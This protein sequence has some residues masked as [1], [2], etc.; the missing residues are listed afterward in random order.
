MR[1]WPVIVSKPELKNHILYASLIGR[2]WVLEIFMVLL[3]I[4]SRQWNIVVTIYGHNGTGEHRI[5]V[6]QVYAVQFALEIKF[7]Q[8]D[9]F[10]L[11]KVQ[12]FQLSVIF[13]R[14]YFLQQGKNHIFAHFVLDSINGLVF[15]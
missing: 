9:G 11:H 3:Q 5:P 4:P 14:P 2:A 10:V 6:A 13:I 7:A 8:K 15:V 12:K 1:P